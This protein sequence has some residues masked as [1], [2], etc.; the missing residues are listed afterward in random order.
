MNWKCDKGHIFS[1]R[2]DI[3]LRGGNKCQICLKEKKLKVCRDFANQHK[4]K[5]LSTE[6]INDRTKMLW[7]CEE[8]HKFERNFIHFKRKR[9]SYF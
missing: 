4:L 2:I 3:I 9:K 7:Q 6:Y 8:G 5:C 1:A